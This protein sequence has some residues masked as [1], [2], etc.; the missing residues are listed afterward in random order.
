MY[1]LALRA[2]FTL[3][4]CR[5]YL[6]KLRFTYRSEEFDILLPQINYS[7]SLAEITR[8]RKEESI[9]IGRPVAISQAARECFTRIIPLL[10]H[11]NQTGIQAFPRLGIVRKVTLF[12]KCRCIRPIAIWFQ[13]ARSKIN[14]VIFYL[15]P[16]MNTLILSWIKLKVSFFT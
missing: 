6:I 10:P 5:H 15:V 7:F 4:Q 14:V 3:T 13:T 12:E 8:K 16:N 1:I 11:S 2:L 9:A